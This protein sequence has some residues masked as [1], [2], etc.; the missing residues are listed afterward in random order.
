MVLSLEVPF[1]TLVLVFHGRLRFALSAA[2]I[3]ATIYLVFLL[4]APDVSPSVYL[5]L[6][7]GSAITAAMRAVALFSHANKKQASWRRIGPN[8]GVAMKICIT[9][10]LS[11]VHV[12]A[13][14]PAFE[15]H[16][17]LFQLT[18]NVLSFIAMEAVAWPLLARPLQRWFIRRMTLALPTTLFMAA[19]AII[20]QLSIN[21]NDTKREAAAIAD[22]ERLVGLL[23]RQTDWTEI[24]IRSMQV[25]YE[26]SASVEFSEF[27]R[28]VSVLSRRSNGIE[29][30]LWIPAVGGATEF[31]VDGIVHLG[32]SSDLLDI[33]GASPKQNA[34]VYMVDKILAFSGTSYDFS[35]KPGLLDV[36]R[37]SRS[38]P[39]GITLSAPLLEENVGEP[40]IYYYESIYLP[41]HDGFVVVRVRV[42]E[43]IQAA[44]EEDIHWG[45]NLKFQIRGMLTKQIVYSQNASNSEPL[46]TASRLLK[47]GDR[48]AYLTVYDDEKFPVG[49]DFQPNR[50]LA[51]GLLFACLCG[52]FGFYI[53]A[54]NDKT[55]LAIRKQRSAQR[56]LAKTNKRLNESQRLAS[57]GAMVAGIA[58]EVNT[59]LSVA[60]LGAENIEYMCD[61][62]SEAGSDALQLQ[63]LQKQIKGSIRRLKDNLSRASTLINDFKRVSADRV[64]SRQADLK[65][66]E[67]LQSVINLLQPKLAVHQAKCT[68]RSP[69]DLTITTRPGLLS[70]ALIILI[71]NALAHGL[72]DKSRGVVGVSVEMHSHHVSIY[73]CDNGVGIA[74]DIREKIFES[75]YTSSEDGSG[76]GLGLYLAKNIVHN[77]LGGSLSLA[78]STAGANFKIDLPLYR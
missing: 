60:L 14:H 64:T 16:L 25:L 26:A 37:S 15:L 63:P 45:E 12:Y 3:L 7:V 65:L 9:L 78:P 24:T 13:F 49:F 46:T 54:K 44:L 59:P 17:L 20:Y 70:Q 5:S 23:A 56:T 55:L 39:L 29:R 61:E 38:N 40:Y 50:I 73:V 1:L 6:F 57:L 42:D 27:R 22:T 11:I 21:A 30:T 35:G 72:K 53:S 28:A 41:S 71:D 62:L 48:G 18:I 2:L 36:L 47:L 34:S 67:F 33:D 58:H 32:G 31:P 75:F 77:Q 4:F 74:E 10:A 43:L 51:I 68:L 52:A 8:Y 19:L 66:K 76:T 69:A